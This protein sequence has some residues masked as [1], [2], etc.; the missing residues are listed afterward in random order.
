MVRTRHRRSFYEDLP[1]LLSTVPPNL[2]GLTEEQAEQLRDEERRKQKEERSAIEDGGGSGEGEGEDER[3]GEAGGGDQ[4]ALLLAEEMKGLAVVVEEGDQ[5][6]EDGGGSEEEVR[7]SEVKGGEGRGRDVR[8]GKLVWSIGTV[9]CCVLLCF[10]VW[11][12]GVV[13]GIRWC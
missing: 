13:G 10:G 8:A 6:E 1:D 2:L 5:G 7:Q 4:E 9:Y 11:N 12:E 3:S